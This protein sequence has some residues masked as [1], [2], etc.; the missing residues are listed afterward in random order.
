MKI[1]FDIETWKKISAALENAPDVNPSTKALIKWRIENHKA[2]ESI[3]RKYV[4]QAKK[5]HHFEGDTEIY[6]G[7]EVGLS[8]L[9][10]GAFVEA[11][12]WIEPGHG[13]EEEHIEH[14]LR[15][16]GLPVRGCG[17]N[18]DWSTR[19]WHLGPS[20]EPN[21]NDGDLYILDSETPERTFALVRHWPSRAE[22]GETGASVELI[23]ED[24]LAVVID[25]A[26]VVLDGN[27]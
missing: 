8:D 22:E 24:Q 18:A 17:L 19:A 15:L 11:W 10:V 14:R 1:N 2:N 3:A 27:S 12:I 13:L 6:E 5:Q 26:L 9:S 20:A 7:A 25:Y 4:A 16:A 23:V 21:R